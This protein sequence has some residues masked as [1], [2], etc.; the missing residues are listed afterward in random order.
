MTIDTASTTSS[1]SY[2][3]APLLSAQSSYAFQKDLAIGSLGRER[4][5]SFIDSTELL[6]LED[7][8]G[9]EES[10]RDGVNFRIR[11]TATGDESLVVVKTDS[12]S[13]T[14]NLFLEYRDGGPGWFESSKADTLVYYFTNGL[15]RF[16]H[17]TFFIDLP[18]LRELVPTLGL[19]SRGVMR[20]EDRYGKSKRT[21]G[22]L[23]PVNTLRTSGALRKEYVWATANESVAGAYK[24]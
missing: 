8:T 17:N 2:T 9:D 18:L 7:L 14:G 16:E 23:L 3:R 21:E 15:D 4:L 24:R 6:E 10:L 5:I 1:H 20:S 22:W 19:Q 12:Y 13:K 11:N